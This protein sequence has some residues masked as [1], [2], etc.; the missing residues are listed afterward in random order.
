MEES[1]FL[2]SDYT[3]KLQSSRQYWHK[4]RNIDQWNK[5]ESPEI[6]PCTYQYLIFD[7]GGKNIQWYSV[8][9]LVSAA[10]KTGQLCVK[11][12]N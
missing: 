10:E 12:R 2:T 6:Y 11:E 8:V 5:T 1:I 9:S 4:N 7:K 3:A